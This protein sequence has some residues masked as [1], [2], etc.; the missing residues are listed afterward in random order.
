MM[1]VNQTPYP[2]I[3]FSSHE[4]INQALVEKKVA[5]MVE[6]N[7]K[8][9]HVINVAE[10]MQSL[11]QVGDL[12]QLAYA[13]SQ[14]FANTCHLKI[15]EI[16]IDYPHLIKE[17]METSMDFVDSCLNAL[18]LHST[19][20]T[21][22]KKNKLELAL[23]QLQKCGALA[24]AMAKASMVLVEKSVALSNQS[25]EALILAMKDK[26]ASY[27]QNQSV[28]K[29]L[30]EIEETEAQLREKTK[31]LHEAIEKECQIEEKALEE[32]RDA[33]N[34]ACLISI[35]M[36]IV[37]MHGAPVQPVMAMGN[38][39]NG[40]MNEIQGATRLII[41]QVSEAV[42]QKQAVVDSLNDLKN[43]LL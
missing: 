36:A 22:A 31:L 21:L 14:G 23:K 34:K 20:L 4:S 5:E 33:R 39:T 43:S 29:T 13:G 6:A 40:I 41:D 8:R 17:S 30:A 19:A 26:N 1:D 2:M 15:G 42:R 10:A 25:K 24:E 38:L 9:F 32:A 7:S 37:S 12:L 3:S 18:K 28:Q 11:T 27:E 35:G 16:L